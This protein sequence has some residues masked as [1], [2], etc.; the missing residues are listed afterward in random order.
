MTTA[1]PA[2]DGRMKAGTGV[3]GFVPGKGLRLGRPRPRFT[4]NQVHNSAIT[5][6]NE[7]PSNR[8]NKVP[9]HQL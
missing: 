4:E 6:V 2:G 1:D 5:A 3:F 7:S 8:I 9:G